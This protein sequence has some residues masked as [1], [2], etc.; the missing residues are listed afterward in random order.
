[1]PS[2]KRTAVIITIISL[3]CKFFGFGREMILAYF[4]GTT[5]IIDAYLV[6]SNIPII[7]FGFL[8][9]ISYAVTPIYKDIKFNI[10]KE[11]S[12]TFVNNILSIILIISVIGIFFGIVFNKQIVSIVAPGF[13]GEVF[14]LTSYYFN[15]SIWLIL[16][17]SPINILIAFLNCNGKFVSSH[18]ASLVI[19]IGQFITVLIAGFTSSNILI[20]GVILSNI[21]QLIV[22]YLFS[23][24]Q[25]YVF[26]YEIKFTAEMKKAFIMVL[27]IMLT[28]MATQIN[29]FV[30]KSFASNLA[31]GSIAAL[32]YGNLL[33]EFLLV[34]FSMAIT[35]MIYPMLSQKVAEKKIDEVK[36][37]FLKSVNLI[38][39]LF[40]PL[41]IGS[42]ILAS[43]TISFIF[44]RG[45]FNADSTV[46]TTL[47]FTMY[48]I[49]LLA[50]ALRDVIT[51]VFYSMQDTKPTLLIG[52][53]SIGLNILFNI[54]LIKYMGHAGLALATSLST[55]IST[56]IFF[57]ILSKKLGSLKLKNTLILFLKS[58]IATAIMGMAVYLESEWLLTVL[59]SSKLS[60][61][62][63]IIVSSVIGGIIYFTLMII[64]RV[65]E[66][67]FFTDIIKKIYEK[68]VI[69]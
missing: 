35:T 55:I 59:I 18:I 7:L 16:F 69:R 36:N 5:Y 54:I 31:E 38:I 45:E 67:Y 6:A 1:M 9:S 40:I 19:S 3:V 50:L 15:V 28:G 2:I 47:A 66:M 68:L 63:T 21:L 56:P 42:I 61:L 62:F 27:P 30:D 8:V 58:C 65:K 49:G 46:M 57:V 4:F 23:Y 43:P 37:I 26:K 25:G 14:D 53:F 24:K 60:I 11:E 41:T 29:V 13:S 44:E 51:K 34:V 64:L 17:M 22:L 10:G 12:N 48:S 39:I 32:N 20:Y 33:I 52:I